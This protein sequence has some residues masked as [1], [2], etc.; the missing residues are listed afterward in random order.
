MNEA[1]L[2]N[3]GA[4]VGRFVRKRL[5]RFFEVYR[6]LFLLRCIFWMHSSLRETYQVDSS[7]EYVHVGY[8]SSVFNT[9]GIIQEPPNKSLCQLLGCLFKA[10][11]W[12]RSFGCEVFMLAHPYGYPKAGPQKQS[13]LST[14]SERVK[15]L[16]IGARSRAWC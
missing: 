14:R 5:K 10:V 16:K 9:S 11:F 13:A 2:Q 1:G 6:P 12:I 3:G 8:T 15:S 7:S 4:V